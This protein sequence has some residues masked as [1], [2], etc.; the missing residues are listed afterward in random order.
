MKRKMTSQQQ[1][2]QQQTEQRH[3]GKHLFSFRLAAVILT[4]ITCLTVAVS[5]LRAADQATSACDPQYMDALEARAWLEAQREI[6]QNAN[7]IF[8]PDSV[9][10]Y[11]CFDK[12]A[13]AIAGDGGQQLFSEKGIPGMKPS[14]VG[15]AS[16]TDAQINNYVILSMNGYISGSFTHSYLN[17]RAENMEYTPHNTSGDPYFCEQ[18]ALVWNAARCMNF[19]DQPD[20]DGFFDFEY[21]A[22]H[23]PRT[24]PKD[25]PACTPPTKPK[26]YSQ[27]IGEAFNQHSEFYTLKDENKGD[28]AKYEEDTVQSNVQQITPDGACGDVHPVPTGL[29]VTRSDIGKTYPE[30]VCPKP[31]CYYDPAGNTCKTSNSTAPS[32]PAAAPASGSK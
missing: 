3:T 14:S 19:F 9:L 18:M 8:K 10:Q 20:S 21:Y 4:M 16:S 11:T 17:D 27:Q 15:S 7:L 30:K 12:M 6:S 23:D 24:L 2:G 26:S 13:G 25:L 32:K 22:K 31:G 29:N 28:G 1:T 5:P